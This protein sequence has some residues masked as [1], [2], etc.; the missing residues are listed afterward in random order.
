[1]NLPE[2]VDVVVVN[3]LPPN[4]TEI[5]FEGANPLP[6]T[7]MVDVGGPEVVDKAIPTVDADA[8]PTVK[9]VVAAT[10]T[11]VSAPITKDPATTAGRHLPR[12]ARIDHDPSL[13][14]RPPDPLEAR[15]QL[16]AWT[17]L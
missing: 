2:A 10:E 14:G 6:V 4:V 5:L 13:L 8:V 7:L 16:P 1:V 12:R 9:A 15:R 3:G 17:V 11:A